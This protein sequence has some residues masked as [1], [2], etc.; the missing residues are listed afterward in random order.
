VLC[1]SI[2]IIEVISYSAVLLISC[3]S[4]LDRVRGYTSSCSILDY[5]NQTLSELYALTSNSPHFTDSDY[6]TTY[7]YI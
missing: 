4:V 2:T 7:R 6:F 5:K 1:K 3:W